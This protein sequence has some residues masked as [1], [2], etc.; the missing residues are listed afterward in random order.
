M[1]TSPPPAHRLVGIQ[2]T[3]SDDIA[4]NQFRVAA[5]NKV[6]TYLYYGLENP[7]VNYP[8][9]GATDIYQSNPT[10]DNFEDY[11]DGFTRGLNFASGRFGPDQQKKMVEDCEVLSAN[12]DLVD[13]DEHHC[14]LNDLKAHNPTAF[15]YTSEELLR[16]A[17]VGF[18][19]S[20][21]Y[22]ELTNNYKSYAT[23][24]GFLSKSDTEVNVMWMSFNSTT[25]PV[26]S[27]SPGVGL[28]SA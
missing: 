6:Q 4:D 20:D 21:K 19:A 24:T 5:G 22:T 23:S 18:Y 14:L 10:G 9:P 2:G 16:N 3:V 25:P 17:L 12:E 28:R 11:V 26:S 1:L 7:A 15:P 13:G 8:N 27:W